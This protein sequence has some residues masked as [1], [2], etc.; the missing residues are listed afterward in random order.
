M[1]VITWNIRKAKEN[2]LVWQILES[3]DADIILLQEVLRIPEHIRSSYNLVFRP[4]ISESGKQ[5]IFGTA[6]LTKYSINH[7][8]PLVSGNDFVQQELDFFKGNLIPVQLISPNHELINVMSVYSPPWTIH[9]SRYEGVNISE[10]KLSLNKRLWVLNI[11]HAW[12][13]DQNGDDNWIIAGDFNSS[14]TFDYLWK[15]GPIG[16]LEYIQRLENLG[17]KECL[18]H[19]KNELVPTFRN[20][21]GGKIIHQLDHMYTSS[22]LI[23]NLIHCKTEEHDLIFGNKLS[24]HLPIISTFH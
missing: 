2:S 14:E 22:S 20:S 10:I 7:E 13:K 16:S 24:D 19:Y 15:G 1:K 17:L 8:I 6:V 3:H 11:L 4:A 9:P 23:E 18:R 5:Q 12:L 21:K